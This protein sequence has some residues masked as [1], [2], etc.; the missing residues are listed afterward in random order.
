MI[1]ASARTGYAQLEALMAPLRE[2]HQVME[3]RLAPLAE[4]ETR[5]LIALRLN[6]RPEELSDDL[7][8]RMHELCGGNPFFVSE[9]VR[10]WFEKDAITRSDDGWV[11]ATEAGDASDLPQTVRDA[12][13]LRIEG[14]PAKAQQVLGAAA[15]IGAVVDI[16]LLRDVLSDLTET[17][18]L[19][20]IDA[21]LPRRVFRETGNAGR[22]EFVH[23]LLRE[24]PYGDLS[25]TRRR[26]LHR[27]VGELLERRRE[28]GKAVA[29]A[30]LAD[31]FK[32]AED[33]PK[34]F[35]YAIEAAQAALDAYAFN[36]A[37]G[38]LNDALDLMPDDA[39]DAT[40][41]RLWEMLGTA[42]GSSGRLDDAIAAYGGP[43]TRRGR[44]SRATVQDGIGEAYHRKGL[45]DDAIRHFDVALREVG[46][47]RP[48]A[49]SGIARYRR[50]RPSSST[51]SHRGCASRTT[52]RTA[53]AESRSHSRQLR[54]AR[55]RARGPELDPLHPL[56]VQAGRLR[57]AVGE[58]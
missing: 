18:V 12:M 40:H 54:T 34:A 2:R 17:D 31:H 5:E 27:R 48:R 15:V 39:E 10:E 19:D 45:F 47:P 1:V 11:L 13:R 35:A 57:Q 42:Y 33:R 29:P 36:N 41:Y 58:A 23:D 28:Q 9:T 32:N 51:C 21:L 24:L 14:L 8:S 22:V 43:R 20:A 4:G 55:P 16:D 26:S 53:T 6:C 37:I 30:V 7:V 46:Y 56:F 3:L 38:H 49:S 44:L 52:D 50:R 25:A